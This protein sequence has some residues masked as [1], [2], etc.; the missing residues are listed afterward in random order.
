MEYKEEDFLT[1]LGLSNFAFCRRRWALRFIDGLWADNYYT[2]DGSALHD[3]VHD[4]EYVGSRKDLLLVRGMY[5][6]SF[7][8]GVSGQCD[9]VEFRR[10]E[11]GVVL[12]GREGKWIPFPVEYK[13]SDSFSDASL[14]QLCGQAMCLEEMFSCEVKEGALYYFSKKHR[15]PVV[16]S[17]ELRS[18]VVSMLQEMHEL[19][20]KKRIPVVKKRKVCNACALK[21]YCLPSIMKIPSVDSYLKRCLSD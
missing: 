13:R 9:L 3:K 17:S 8:L 21:D 19:F 7:K 2:A 10:S 15:E 16:F 1:L 14:A 4:V 18:N 6:R 12:F 20:S 5:V 11:D